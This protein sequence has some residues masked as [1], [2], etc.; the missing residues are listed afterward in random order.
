MSD[1]LHEKVLAILAIEAGDPA[2]RLDVWLTRLKNKRSTY[3]D[4]A[5]I[6]SGLDALR[7]TE[8]GAYH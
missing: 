3:L 5:T 1:K 8:K 7:R 4:V 2:Y 6:T